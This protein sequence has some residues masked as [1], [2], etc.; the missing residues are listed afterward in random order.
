MGDS[1]ARQ[2]ATGAV[3]RSRT[4]VDRSAI[5]ARVWRM[6]Q[7]DRPFVLL[8]VLSTIIAA[9][10]LLAGSAAVV[11]GAMLIAPLMGPILGVALGV[12]L[13]DSIV[14]RRALWSEVI[15]VALA[16]GLSAAIGL[17]PLQ[18]GYGPEIT[19]RTTPTLYDLVIALCAGAAAAY[20]LV[21][22]RVSPTLPGVAIATALV[23]PLAAC[24]LCV[25]R[26]RWSWAGGAF[27]LFVA[28]SIA[29]TT[30]GAATFLALGL[31]RPGGGAASRL[32][33][34][35]RRFAVHLLA[36]IVVGAYMTR[37][38]MG[39]IADHRL[40]ESLR[41]VVQ[42]EIADSLGAQL[43]D[44][45][46]DRRPGAIEVMATVLTAHP[47]DS[48]T[49]AR[50]E[51]AA[52][53]RV[54]PTVHMVLRSVVTHD[55]DAAGPVFVPDEEKQ[56][57]TEETERTRRLAVASEVLRRAFA[58]APGAVL[59]E[60]SGQPSGGGMTF[61]AVV[62]A[63][64][65][66]TPA[67]VASAEERLTRALGLECRLEVQSVLVRT[68]RADGYADAEP[69]AAGVNALE[70]ARWATL[71]QAALEKR[72]DSVALLGVSAD[73]TGD[74]PSLRCAVQAPQSAGPPI[75]LAARD[76]LRARLHPRLS[77]EV[78]TL[79]AAAATSDGYRGPADALSPWPVTSMPPA[80]PL[81]RI[82][83]DPALALFVA[84]AEG[85]T[86]RAEALLRAVPDP[87]AAV[88]LG[89]TPLHAAARS[90]N[91]ALVRV[92]LEH[93]ADPDLPDW[94]GETP[95]DWATA[96]SLPALDAAGIS[97]DRN[98][99]PR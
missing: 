80:R 15:G 25:A 70:H 37:T 33:P 24:G 4:A 14:L 88:V 8:L 86:A 40:A 45:R 21:D 69:T 89:C 82:D 46:S 56:R 7:P 44:L 87:S 85:D 71:V 30:V 63:P 20:A 55:M 79:V 62:R 95:R 31:R 60:L 50:I 48:E 72:L 28:N 74:G 65:P 11:I 67:T 42:E 26:Q 78:Q 3:R 54:D 19:S 2:E 5:R 38:L 83:D 29:I 75:V 57:E 22:A 47:M 93:G 52:R 49:V 73:L 13:G 98:D 12:A 64:R 66:I 36:L 90:G 84:C 53:E 6:S 77:L 35:A 68:A 76:W 59:A 9:C 91:A 81:E 16:V 92:L 34:R 43:T 94:F 99:A 17:V 1:A 58:D 39:L 41:R 96:A 51:S 61:L 32:G 23:P 97:P 27:L 10:G 18:L